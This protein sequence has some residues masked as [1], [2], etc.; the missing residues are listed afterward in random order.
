[1]HFAFFEVVKVFRRILKGM[2]LILRSILEK[3]N[4]IT[5]K[6]RTIRIRISIICICKCFTSG[7]DLVTVEEGGTVR[8]IFIHKQKSK[9][10]CNLALTRKDVKQKKR[11][12][13]GDD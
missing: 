11:G 10:N 1:M 7:S 12:K 4:A 6:T 2:Y 9:I 8:Q 5:Q 3:I 13:G